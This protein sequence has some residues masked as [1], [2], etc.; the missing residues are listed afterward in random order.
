MQAVA[1]LGHKSSASGAG[2][3]AWYSPKESIH[4]ELQGMAFLGNTVFAVTTS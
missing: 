3:V 2:L 1:F 4:R